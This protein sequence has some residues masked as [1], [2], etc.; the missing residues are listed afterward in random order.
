MPCDID[1][2][3][4]E[5]QSFRGSIGRP[6]GRPNNLLHLSLLFS[7]QRPTTRVV[8]LLSRPFSARGCALYSAPSRSQRRIYR[9]C[10]F[11]KPPLHRPFTNPPTRHPPYLP[12]DPPAGRLPW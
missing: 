7:F 9:M 4:L 8:R 2:L 1:W 10:A 5:T 3:L 12:I 6:E 11:S